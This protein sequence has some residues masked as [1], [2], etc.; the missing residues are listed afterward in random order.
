MAIILV[1]TLIALILTTAMLHRA[2]LKIVEQQRDIDLLIRDAGD[3]FERGRKQGHADADAEWRRKPLYVEG[4]QR[5][6][7]EAAE[8]QAEMDALRQSGELLEKTV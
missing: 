8:I 4:Y 3:V 7:G 1:L 5:G 2:D 6:I